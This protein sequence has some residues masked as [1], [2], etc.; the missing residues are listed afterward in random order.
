MYVNNSNCDLSPFKIYFAATGS[1]WLIG[2]DVDWRLSRTW[3]RYPQ[4]EASMSSHT[5]DFWLN[6]TDLCLD[7]CMYVHIYVYMYN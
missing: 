2:R 3:F 4:R 6:E 1:W 7:D 5:D